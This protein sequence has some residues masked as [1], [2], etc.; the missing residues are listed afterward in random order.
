MNKKRGSALILPGHILNAVL[1]LCVTALGCLSWSRLPARI[2]IHFQA[3]GTP[4]RW[5]QKGA[6]LFLVFVLPWL[7]SG[8]FYGLGVFGNWLEKYPQL[9]NI[10][11]KEKFLTL[12]PQSRGP[13]YAA[14]TELFV[15]MAVSTNLLF[16]GAM[17]GM[18]L[19]ALGVEMQLPWWSIWPGLALTMVASLFSTVRMYVLISNLADAN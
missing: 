10:P 8:L 12:P 1:L 14:F 7:T 19:V 3:N 15:L 2:P 13:V 4:D 9:L 17:C 6:E 16:L 11:N 5:T 18:L